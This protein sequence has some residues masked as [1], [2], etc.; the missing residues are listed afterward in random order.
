VPEAGL[1]AE[2]LHLLNAWAEGLQRDERA[3]VAAAGRAI[4]MLV[5]EVERLHVLIWDKRLNPDTAEPEALAPVPA[6]AEVEASALKREPEPA[7]ELEQSLRSRL[8]ARLQGA[9]LHS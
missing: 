4:L 1:D 5:E 7:P 3:E 2:K 9:S 6:T 8:R